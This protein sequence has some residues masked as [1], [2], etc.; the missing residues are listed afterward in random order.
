M[1]AK[2]NGS[3]MTSVAAYVST[4]YYVLMEGK[5][6]VGPDVVP[7]PAGTRCAV[8]YGFSGKACYDKFLANSSAGLVPYPLTKFYLQNQADTASDGINLVVV[9][10]AGP[11][12]PCLQ[13]GTMEA[14]L[15]GQEQRAR[16]VTAAYQ[17]TLDPGG[18][19]YQVAVNKSLKT[20]QRLC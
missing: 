5:R 9:D 7:L 19:A 17:L 11:H 16:H 4:P 10:A 20:R 18:T 13:A 12:E 6:R 2:Y 15:Q 14:V 3:T 8:V 1:P